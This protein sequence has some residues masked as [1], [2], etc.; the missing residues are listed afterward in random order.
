MGAAAE[1]FDLRASMAGIERRAIERA[2]ARNRHNQRAT[3]RH[4][5]L[6]YDQLRNRLKKHGLL[7]G[8][9]PAAPAARSSGT[10]R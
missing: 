2:L 8:A 5:D 7:E 6:T 4:L 10:A 1:P 9:R 3:A